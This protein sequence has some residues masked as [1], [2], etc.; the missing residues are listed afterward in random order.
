MPISVDADQMLW[1]YMPLTAWLSW[2]RHRSVFFPRAA[3]LS[4]DHEGIL[5]NFAQASI[6]ALPQHGDSKMLRQWFN[7]VSD[8]RE[9]SGVSSW[10]MS[11]YESA[12][13]WHSY[14]GS[15][16]VTVIS[17][18]A[19]IESCFGD[20]KYPATSFWVRPVQYLPDGVTAED[21]QI[22]PQRGDAFIVH[23]INPL[24]VLWYKR[25]EFETEKELRIIAELT[26]I[27]QASVHPC[28]WDVHDKV[29]TTSGGNYYKVDLNELI[30]EVRVAPDVAKWQFEIISGVTR[31]YLPDATVSR[32]TISVPPSL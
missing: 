31:D 19:R 7:L 16:G 15:D 32:S 27:C 26:R 23:G 18:L 17:S 13:M 14:A 28:R 12:Q 2:L 22:E 29:T 8:T 5:K 25:I 20:Q 11:N 4:D 1:R 10:F 6:Q 30:A 21:I 24:N 9:T 3:L